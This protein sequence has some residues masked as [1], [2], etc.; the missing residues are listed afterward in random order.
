MFATPFY[1]HFD[2]YTLEIPTTILAC[3]AVVLVIPVMLLYFYGATVRKHSSFAQSLAENREATVIKSQ[4]R[5]EKQSRFGQAR[6][7]HLEDA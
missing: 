7:E 6:F 3:I 1:E 2:T 5:D 4:V